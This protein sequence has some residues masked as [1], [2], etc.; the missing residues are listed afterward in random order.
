MAKI[1]AAF[2][3]DQPIKTLLFSDIPFGKVIPLLSRN[4]YKKTDEP[5]GFRV[6]RSNPNLDDFRD[7]SA[8]YVEVDDQEAKASGWRDGGGWYFVPIAPAM[9]KKLL[10]L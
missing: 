1:Y 2:E 10:Q 6:Q 3:G 5:L 8:I 9:A 7:A 4:Q